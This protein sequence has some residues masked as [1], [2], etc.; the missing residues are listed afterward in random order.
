MTIMPIRL[1]RKHGK[2]KLQIGV[3]KGKKE[4]D[5]REAEKNRTIDN[6]LRR[7]IKSQKFNKDE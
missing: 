1:F 2:F 5:K 7:T 3:C 4:Y 6:D